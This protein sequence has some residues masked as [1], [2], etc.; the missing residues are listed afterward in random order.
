M[1]GTL[2]RHSESFAYFDVLIDCI[3]RE[4]TGSKHV[5]KLIRL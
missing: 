4:L 1:N 2:I 5:P 3:L